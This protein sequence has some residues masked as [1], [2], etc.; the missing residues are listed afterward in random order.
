MMR[1]V[2]VLPLLLAASATIPART[3]E[4]D[5]REFQ[6]KLSKD[7]QNL[8]AL[9]RL[10][11]GPRQQDLSE[12]R[13]IGVKKWIDQQ[14]HPERLAENPELLRRLEPLE[15]LRMSQSEAAAAYP[16]RQMLRA[17]AR[18]KQKPPEDPLARAAVDRLSRLLNAQKGEGD[19][20]LEPRRALTE[21]LTPAEIRTLR[22]GKPEEKTNVLAAI[23]VE[24][25]DEVVVAMPAPLRNQLLPV[26]PVVI[27]R[28]LLQANNPQQVVAYDL[29]EAKFYRAIYSTH[30]LEEQLVDFWFNHFNVYLDKGADRYLV[31]SYERDAIRPYVLS[32][33]RD[34][35]ESTANSPAM[36][37]YLD[38][39]ESVAP[40]TQRAPKGKKPTRGLNENYARELMELHTLGV[41]GGY[42]QQDIIEVA[43]CFT[44]WTLRP[45]QGGGFYFNEKVH[46]K[47]QKVVLGVTIPAGGGKEDGE[48]V[49]DIL[50]HHPSTAR[51]VSRKLAQ[52]FVADDPPPALIAKMAQTF[53]DTDGDLRAVM[54]AMLESK[55]FFSQGALRA[56]VKTPFEMMV[57]AIRATGA[58]VEMVYPLGQQLANLG[59]PLYRKLEPTGYSSA[60][61][62]WV[63]S[64]ALLARM[65]F[66][67][68]LGQNKVQ[69]IKVDTAKLSTQPAKAAQQLLFLTPEKETLA[70]IGAALNKEKTK[71]PKASTEAL[72][73]GLI[74]GSPEFQ[75][76]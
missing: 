12:V 38:N 71:N 14:L 30:Q 50:A 44:G 11:Y 70:A 21:L 67:L 75:R 17:I 63:S 41:D 66:A 49:L 59:E 27:R 26:A 8:H 24:Q 69:G 19:E 36:M 65:N 46:D 58:K 1:K 68:S 16:P 47:G 31:P 9:E 4:K 64:S 5:Y 29:N 28:K 53:E 15:S 55:E 33:F 25:I 57:S 60:N 72:V 74:L 62:E 32:K 6:K 23:P 54:T 37:F 56:K 61:A 35:L 22:N 51:F 42:T 3:T 39:W 48:K 18:G 10:T 7:E 76:K 40:E 20:E 34:L 13:R 43:R 73:A 45:N 2:L 52:R